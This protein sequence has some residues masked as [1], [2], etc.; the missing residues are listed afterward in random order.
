MHKLPIYPKIYFKV[1]YSQSMLSLKLFS[2]KEILL[3][4][5]YLALYQK[6]TLSV[7][8]YVNFSYISCTFVTIDLISTYLQFAKLS[9][10]CYVVTF[11]AQAKVVWIL[12]R[13]GGG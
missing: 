2:A 12:G 6:K 4:Y 5:F 10:L 1:F 3:M 8:V 9:D 7:K 11:R 13:K